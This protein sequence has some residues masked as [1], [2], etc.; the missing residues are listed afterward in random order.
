MHSGIQKFSPKILLWAALHDEPSKGE[1]V[2]ICRFSIYIIIYI[3]LLLDKCEVCMAS[4][5]PSFFLPFMAQVWGPWEPGRKK[6]GSVTCGTD[7]ANEANKMFIIWLCW[8]FQFWKGDQEPE[9]HTATYALG[10][11]QSQQAKSVSHIIIYVI[12]CHEILIHRPKIL[13]QYWLLRSLSCIIKLILSP[14]S[15]C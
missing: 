12:I 13:S 8:L 11:D 7:R 3:Y 4:D 9:V 14:K 5:G 6:R 2:Y 1:T 10:I 15:M